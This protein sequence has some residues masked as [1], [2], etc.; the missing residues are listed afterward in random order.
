MH[1]R[2]TGPLNEA[3]DREIER[4]LAVD[5]SAAFESRVRARMAE[6]DL[7][8]ASW[9][10]WGAAMRRGIGVAAVVLLAVAGWRVWDASQ[11]VDQRQPSPVA[12]TGLLLSDAVRPSASS[13]PSSPEPLMTSAPVSRPTA[14][15][16]RATAILLD[17]LPP[18]LVD[19]VEA[20]AMRALIADVREGRFEMVVVSD[21]PP[22]VEPSASAFVRAVPVTS[23]PAVAAA[24]DANASGSEVDD[25]AA[26]AGEPARADAV[27]G[28]E[29]PTGSSQ[30]QMASANLVRPVV[31]TPL[32]IEPLVKGVPDEFEGVAE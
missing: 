13:Q 14:A 5:P 3:L 2:E 32:T 27:E 8:S 25:G 6:R 30:A 28:T 9:R 1:D 24:S 4:M 10:W 20:A 22:V 21:Q 19:P 29:V 18:V 31:I 15:A 7:A 26:D 23:T 11:P 16:R 17:A 12:G